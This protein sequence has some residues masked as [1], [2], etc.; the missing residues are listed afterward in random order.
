MMYR[1]ITPFPPEHYTLLWDWAN[2]FP[3]NNMDDS[4]PVNFNYFCVEMERR[5]ERGETIWEI[6]AFG[7]PVGAVGYFPINREKGAFHGIC[8]TQNV[9]GTGIPRLA[10]E[11]IIQKI[12]DTGVQ[13]IRAAYFSDNIRISK[14][15]KKLGA[16]EV[17]H[18]PRETTRKG[19][20]IDMTTVAIFRP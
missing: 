18:I 2:E 8:F 4:A 12:F 13:Q 20:P 14:F 16:V 17:A 11:E 1:L 5:V 9:H 6:E 19:Q 3:L 7:E 15:L 10:V